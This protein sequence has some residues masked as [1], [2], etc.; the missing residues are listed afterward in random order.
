MITFT[1]EQLAERRKAQQK[2]L[3]GSID[4]LRRAVDRMDMTDM[5]FY[6][7]LV[8]WQKKALVETQT[9]LVQQTYD[10]GAKIF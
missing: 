7:G 6:A 2:A 5:D 4:D 9:L 10:E 3:A 1:L 8:I